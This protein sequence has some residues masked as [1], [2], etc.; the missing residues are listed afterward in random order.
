MSLCLLDEMFKHVYID[1]PSM[2]IHGRAKSFEKKFP[3]V[4]YWPTLSIKVI[5]VDLYEVTHASKAKESQI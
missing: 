3:K 2:Y 1:G 5:V 4:F